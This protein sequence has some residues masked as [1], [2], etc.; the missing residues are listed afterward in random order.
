MTK[1][2]PASVPDD[3]SALR[4]AQSDAFDRITRLASRAVVAPVALLTLTHQERQVLVSSYGLTS[5]RASG[6]GAPASFDF[7]E[8]VVNAGAP[9]AISEAPRSETLPGMAACLGVPLRRGEEHIL[10]SLGIAD[11]TQRVWTDQE[12]ETLS[13]L[14]VL[15][16]AAIELQQ[17]VSRRSKIAHDFNNLLTAIKG[18]ADLLLLDLPAEGPMQ[19]DVA[20]ILRAVDRGAAISR[21]MLHPLHRT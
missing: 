8:R 9:L 4:A 18:N 1:V 10:G 7:P 16:V 14:A 17:E 6:K 2:S 20:E 5:P 3:P 15:A 11:S 12:I 21:Q 19:E 13:D